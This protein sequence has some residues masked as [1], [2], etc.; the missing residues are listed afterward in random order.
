VPSVQAG[1]TRLKQSSHSVSLDSAV[2]LRNKLSRSRA[3]CPSDTLMA[4][5]AALI[6]SPVVLK[7]K[8]VYHEAH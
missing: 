3:L 7:F 1:Q 2:R 4:H 5:V 6:Y 8:L